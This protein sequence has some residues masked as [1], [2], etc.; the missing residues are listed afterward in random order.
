[1]MQISE[2]KT[3]G[4][5]ATLYT[6]AKTAGPLLVLPVFEGNGS[7]ICETLARQSSKPFR[8]LCLSALSWEDDLTPYPAPALS[9]KDR[10]FG[11]QA[12]HLLRVLENDILPWSLSQL[13]KAPDYLGVAGYSL[14]GMF[15]LYA[16]FN[17]RYFT[18]V[19]S[20]SGSL[21]YPDF[22]RYLMQKSA[23]A[24]PLRIYLSLG[25]A[26]SRTRHPQLR[27]VGECTQALYQFLKD[28]H[29]EVKFEEQPGNHFHK[30]TER[31][32]TGLQSLL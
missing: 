27:R 9:A 20:M 26:E 17:C 18:A 29:Y 32:V 8:L 15:A 28:S 16:A 14:A 13:P 21:W 4:R 22:V 3:A 10:P 23:P 30:V 5:L 25:A 31:I 11:G 6:D 19:A 12:E 7:E 24:Q 2:F 1:M